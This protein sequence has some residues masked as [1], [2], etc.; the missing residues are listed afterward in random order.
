MT[1]SRIGGCDAAEE[2][3]DGHTLGAVIEA[4]ERR[5]GREI[6][7]A[8][9]GKGYRGHNARNPRRWGWHKTSGGEP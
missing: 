5:T 6:E 4:T 1:R 7:R 3:R 2:A 8:Y 9:V